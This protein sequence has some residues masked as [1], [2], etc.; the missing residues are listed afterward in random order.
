MS[1]ARVWIV[2]LLAALAVMA[3]GLI[4]P[5]WLLFTVTKAIAFGLVALGIVA[6]M[7]GGPRLVRPGRL[8]PASAP[9]PRA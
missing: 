4:M 6:L 7:R 5:A 8:L 3:L 9:T 2:A 1:G